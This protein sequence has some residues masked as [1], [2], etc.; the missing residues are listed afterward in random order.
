MFLSL[1]SI[2]VN[3]EYWRRAFFS[4]RY[5]WEMGGGSE[6]YFGVDEFKVFVGYF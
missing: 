5:V 3:G 6:F 4:G 1:G 2:D